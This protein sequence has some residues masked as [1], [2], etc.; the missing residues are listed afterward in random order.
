MGGCAVTA[1]GMRSFYRYG[2]SSLPRH[3][4]SRSLVTYSLLPVIASCAA[5]QIGRDL[6]PVSESFVVWRD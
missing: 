1:L 4:R 3:R 5:L 2:E 6:P